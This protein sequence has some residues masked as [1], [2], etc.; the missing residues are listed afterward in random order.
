MQ[1]EK[2]AELMRK[3]MKFYDSN[4]SDL[5]RKY[6][7]KYIIIVGNDVTGNFNSLSEAIS[8]GKKQYGIGNFFVKLCVLNDSNNQYYSSRV[9]FS[10]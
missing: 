3:A 10:L 2:T 5:I 9:N 1:N 8:F 6:E 7:N 4:V